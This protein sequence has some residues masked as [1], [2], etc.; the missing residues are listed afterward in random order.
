MPGMVTHACDPRAPK[1]KARG[2]WEC[3][4]QPVSELK[5]Q[6]ETLSQETNRNENILY[7]KPIL[8]KNVPTMHVQLC[9]HAYT[10]YTPHTHI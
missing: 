1:D 4:A 6:R 8:N 5:V 7:K 2:S 9:V 3:A 10:P